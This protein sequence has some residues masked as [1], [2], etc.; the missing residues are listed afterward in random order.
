MTIIIKDSER[1]T[2]KDWDKKEERVGVK[3]RTDINNEHY[4]VYEVIDKPLFMLAVIKYG[5]EFEEI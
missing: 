4:L 5:M 3:V 1:W 2:Q